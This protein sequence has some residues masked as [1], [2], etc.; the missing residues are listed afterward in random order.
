MELKN[1]FAQDDQ[2]NKLPGALCYLYMR[3]TESPA[4]GA[5]KAN[6]TPLQNPFIADASGFVQLA[7]PNGLYD[8]RVT[9]EGRDN[10]IRLQFNDVSESLESAQAAAQRAEVARDAAQLSAGVYDDIATGLLP[11]NTVSGQYFSVPSDI[12]G[13]F[14][15]LYKNVDGT[16]V[17]INRYSS[18]ELKETVDHIEGKVEGIERGSAP[19]IAFSVEDE[20][21]RSALSVDD[22]GRVRAPSLVVTTM[23]SEAQGVETL[24]GFAI[25]DEAGHMVFALD[26]EGRPIVGGNPPQVILDEWQELTLGADDSIV[27][28]GD[29]YTASHY[30]LKDKAYISQLSALSPYRHQNFGVSGHDLLDMQYRIIHGDS[31]TGLML[32]DMRAKYAFLT[33]LT[34]DAQFRLADKSYYAE[35]LGRLIDTVR[36]Y[37]PEPV[38]TT[39]FPATSIE[40]A[41]LARVAQEYGC[42]FIDCTSYDAEVGGLQ[43]GPFHQ[44]HPGTR[45]GGVFWLPMLEFIDRLPKPERA[46]KIY[47]RR[48]TQAVVSSADLLYKGRVDRQKKWKELTVFHYSI[49]PE[50]KFEEL[51]QLGTP[52]WLARSDEY[53]K[54]AAGK[55]VSF[56][57][58]ALFE[59][60][61]PGTAGTLDGV[62]V[63]LSIQGTPSVF[64]RDYLD[65]AAGMPGKV[66]GSKPTDATYLSKWDKPR[67]AWRALGLYSSKIVLSA[68]DLA[69]SMSGNTLVLM[70]SGAF[71]LSGLNV[72]YK[73]RERRAALPAKRSARVI[74]PDLL[75]QP[76]SGT[77]AQLAA[78]TN[79]GA[80]V[81]MVPIDLYN[82]PR[83]PGLNTPVDGVCVISATDMI[84]QVVPLP[85]ENG[86]A[87]RYRLVVWARYFPK[88][89][90]DPT[91]YPGIDLTQVIDRIA[92][93]NSAPITS[94]THDL[95]TLKCEMWTGSA[96]Y[97]AAGGAEFMDFAALQY[98]PIAFEFDAVPYRTGSTINFRLSCPDGE[99]Q[100]A[101]TQF[102]EIES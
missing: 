77:P 10:R 29:S 71:S 56:T 65:V 25:T 1:F 52:G 44:G 6:G 7:A 37:G 70:L 40:H 18:A 49:N 58:Y 9:S 50:S 21:G 17:E 95:R 11:K 28:I 76:L 93:P 53:Q 96:A 61:L 38:I 45:T 84:G 19:F 102:W 63:E 75:A 66:Q 8:I 41:F 39:E 101:K 51:N 48:S 43:L 4:P 46:I 92:Q 60:T 31:S 79:V 85:A 81:T 57:D 24:I 22:S 64:V 94:D 3:G 73:G 62:E 90:L 91:L 33:S 2:G 36:A 100:V 27:H 89:F 68:A 47:R 80:P 5:V 23:E 74:G 88:A 97:P 16:A 42:A 87:R 13:E 78:W 82:A 12:S 30:A 54:I 26:Q 72:R 35:N 20:D 69:K 59:V 34:N 83:K 67:G 15:I 86:Q 14:L 32:G 99:I 98:R 55:A